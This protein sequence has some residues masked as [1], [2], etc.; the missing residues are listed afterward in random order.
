MKKLLLL[1]LITLAA[2]AFAEDDNSS[3]DER[4]SD[5]NQEESDRLPE[6]SLQESGE[7]FV[8]SETISEELSVPFPVDI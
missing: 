3:P 5:R 6:M 4:S 8:P 1:I 2:A 7:V